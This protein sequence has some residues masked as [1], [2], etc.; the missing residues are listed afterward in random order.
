MIGNQKRHRMFSY[1]KRVIRIKADKG[2]RGEV[3]CC[4]YPD[5]TCN[6]RLGKTKGNCLW[7]N[8][9]TRPRGAGWG[10][11]EWSAKLHPPDVIRRLLR[12]GI[13]TYFLRRSD[14]NQFYTVPYSRIKIPVGSLRRTSSQSTV[15]NIWNKERMLRCI[16]SIR[17]WIFQG[18]PQ[19]LLLAIYCQKL[20]WSKCSDQTPPRPFSWKHQHTFHLELILR[21]ILYLLNCIKSSKLSTMLR[22]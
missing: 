10:P 6:W 17:I 4:Y 18:R 22:G 1:Y 19:D 7:W 20:T 14:R 3:I 11:E 12:G 5:W 16:V 13:L 9:Q 8:V 2:G 21:S 15:Q